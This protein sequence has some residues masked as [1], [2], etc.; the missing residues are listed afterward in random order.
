[1]QGGA[2]SDRL[3]ESTIKDLDG[4]CYSLSECLR[5]RNEGRHAQPLRDEVLGE[6]G[7]LFRRMHLEQDNIKIAI[8]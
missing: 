6:L 3:V 2:L 4:R 5:V 8:V 7:S 1:V